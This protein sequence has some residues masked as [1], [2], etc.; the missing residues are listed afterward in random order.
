[1]T[2]NF[3]ELVGLAE[4]A[5]TDCDTR[6]IQGDIPEGQQPRF[7][8]YHATGSICSQKTRCVLAELAV[9]YI[10][11]EIP[12]VTDDWAT[13][14]PDYVRMRIAGSEGASL[15]SGHTGSTSAS[16]HGFDPT[17]VPTLVDREAAVIV[18]DSARICRYIDAQAG[19]SA[20]RPA[21]LE[22]QIERQM[23]I[24]DD[25]PHVA[26]AFGTHP[27]FDTRP[28]Q[29]KVRTRGAFARKIEA[30]QSIRERNIA[31][32]DIV[33]AI[34]AKLGKEKAMMQLA[35]DEPFMNGV[36][37]RTA[38]SIARLEEELSAKG[39]EWVCGDTFSMA[40]VFWAVNLYRLQSLGLNYL[41]DPDTQPH[42]R[43]VDR[44]HTGAYAERLINRPAFRQ[45]V[46]D[47]GAAFT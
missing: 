34:D 41:W 14:R 20:L 23:A 24:V 28:E 33:R 26:L 43:G 7:E 3:D 2:E 40:D 10:S 35:D 29:V 6:T 22:A 30:L 5:L 32:Q 46:A 4:A 27:G 37:H 8:L 9:P 19:D 18:V 1:M 25:T 11:H 45:S 38:E 21:S 36:L 15:V 39:S 13:Y 16:Q 44:P 31:N 17:V 47:W 42:A 12:I